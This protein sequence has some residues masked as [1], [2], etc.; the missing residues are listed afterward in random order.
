MLDMPPSAHGGDG[1]T[2]LIAFLIIAL[3]FSAVML[4]NRLIYERWRTQ[5]R[6]TSSTRASTRGTSPRD[7]DA[8]LH[9]EYHRGATG[10][11][12]SAK[13]TIDF[14]SAQQAVLEALDRAGPNWMS[15]QAIANSSSLPVATA[16]SILHGRH[17]LPIVWRES[18][19]S[20]ETVYRLER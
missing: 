19:K 10:R 18:R 14:T 13:E 15:V 9:S 17:G 1:T 3:I 11:D 20:H 16:R 4:L 12:S 7:S 5:P 8:D 6:S 2:L